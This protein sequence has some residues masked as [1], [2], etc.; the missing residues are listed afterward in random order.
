MHVLSFSA[1][2]VKCLFPGLISDE[3]KGYPHF[4]QSYPQILCKLSGKSVYKP[5]V[6]FKA[7]LFFRI[8]S[9]KL[10]GFSQV[11]CTDILLPVQVSNGTR[12]L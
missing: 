7:L 12:N 1:Q 3:H 2:G 5:C 6:Y 9:T 10:N 11:A 8:E 4:P